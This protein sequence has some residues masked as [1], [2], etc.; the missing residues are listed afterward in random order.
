M[1]QASS[2]TGN[3]TRGERFLLAVLAILFAATELAGVLLTPESLRFIPPRAPPGPS[4]M[5]PSGGLV[6]LGPGLKVVIARVNTTKALR[7]LLDKSGFDLE[8]IRDGQAKT[9]ALFLASL[10]GD[11]ANIKSVQERKDLFVSIALPLILHHNSVVLERRARLRGLID[12]PIGNLSAAD[13]QWL[14]R[15]ARLYRV[16][17]PDAGIL[18]ITDATGS[19]LLRRV[20][21]IPISLA[22]AQSAAE[23]G[24]GT[25]RFARR[26]NALFGQW[27]WEQG[28]GLIPNERVEGRSHTVRAFKRLA[29]SVQAYVHNLNISH[30]YAGFRSGRALLRRAGAP[31]GTWGHIL[32]GHLEKYSEEGVDYINKIRLIIRVNGFGDLETA[33]IADLARPSRQDPPDS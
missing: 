20:D 19:V 24:W 18:A 29:H 28:S 16:I 9:P 26:G 1:T 13:R 23:S 21:T 11:L 25:S 32:A 6:D 5:A 22:L 7:G 4:A 14:L 15:L 10:P 8:A 30:H 2:P 31:D 3:V 27:T 12:R 17:E 33:K